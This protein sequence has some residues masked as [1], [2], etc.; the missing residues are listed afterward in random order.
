MRAHKAFV[1]VSTLLP[2]EVSSQGIAF[3][4]AEL[5]GAAVTD[6]WLK[7][8]QGKT[9]RTK[10]GLLTKEERAVRLRAVQDDS[11]SLEDNFTGILKDRRDP[12]Y[13][14][15]RTGSA[16]MPTV[17]QHAAPATPP[18]IAPPPPIDRAF[19]QFAKLHR[20]LTDAAIKAALAA[21]LTA[22]AMAVRENDV[23]D[24]V[25][26]TAAVVHPLP[27]QRTMTTEVLF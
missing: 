9:L 17:V 21:E 14:P 1:C 11:F 7:N 5:H 22:M 2:P 23:H 3:A 15:K 12:S 6:G 24:V 10:W 25:L 8:R 18:S 13:Y 4:K 26:R 20:E 27:A 19:S 16:D